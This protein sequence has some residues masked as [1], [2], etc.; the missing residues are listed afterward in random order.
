MDT[1]QFWLNAGVY[2]VLFL[3][4][5]YLVYRNFVIRRRLANGSVEYLQL[6]LDSAEKI[7][8]LQQELEK[9][10]REALTQTDGFVKFISESRDWAFNYIEDVQQSIQELQTAV[11]GGYP[12]EEKMAKLF[13]L[14]PEN[15]EK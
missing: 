12:T 14:L 2:A 4:V 1:L 7:A 9:R 3:L 13:S 5:I 11:E 6:K 10:D 8:F 15:K